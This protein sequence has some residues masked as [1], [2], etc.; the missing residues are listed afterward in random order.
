MLMTL[1][2]YFFFFCW[3]S[4]K[5]HSPWSHYCWSLLLDVVKSSYA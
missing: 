5:Y 2:F 3:I 1:S 4:P